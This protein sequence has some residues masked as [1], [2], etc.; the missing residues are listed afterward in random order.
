MSFDDF[1][2]A[3]RAGV[4]SGL[5]ASRNPNRY[6]K[7]AR[8]TQPVSYINNDD[9]EQEERNDFLKTVQV[10]SSKIQ[11]INTNVISL[12]KLMDSFG[13]VRDTPDI[14]EQVQELTEDT[15][16]I[17]REANAT[18]K[19]LDGIDDRGKRM[20][21]NQVVTGLKEV[22]QRFAAFEQRALSKG[23]KAVENLRDQKNL[24]SMEDG[25]NSD[26]EKERLWH[27]EDQKERQLAAFDQ[28]VS[29]SSSLIQE[30]EEGMKEIERTMLEVNDIYRDLATIV[31]E[32]GDQL[33][34]IEANMSFVENNVE[35]G[36][37]NLVKANT[38]Q[39]KARTKMCCLLAILVIIGAIIAVV[40]AESNKS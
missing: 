35:Q 2:Q 18:T 30:R 15:K 22:I 16:R 23:R 21:L 11:S 13:T 14:R 37:V 31:H 12:N 8:A 27:E 20:K 10:L 3:P 36:V 6:T 34:N 33:D 40:V 24:M 32:Q 7:V 19:Q 9:D 17:I 1:D 5:A 29:Y 25:Y 26:S 38:Y 39:K 4:T 28:Q